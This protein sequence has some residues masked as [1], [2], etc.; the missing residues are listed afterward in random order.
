VGITEKSC[1]R[2][3]NT[4]Y[5]REAKITVTVDFFSSE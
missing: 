5:N 2:R 3:E 1:Q 4:L